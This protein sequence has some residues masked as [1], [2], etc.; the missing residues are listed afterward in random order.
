VITF[1]AVQILS[2]GYMDPLLQG[3]GLFV[4]AGVAGMVASGVTVI[5]RMSRVDV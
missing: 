2:P 4:M 1:L 5:K 3:K